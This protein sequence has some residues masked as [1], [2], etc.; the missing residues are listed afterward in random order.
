MLE[1]FVLVADAAVEL[2][3][4]RDALWKAIQRKRL[5]V[6]RVGR[7]ILIHRSHLELFRQQ[8]RRRGRPP[9]KPPPA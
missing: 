5:P 9:R 6:T 2:G 3:M 1:D 4:S 7:S 8:P